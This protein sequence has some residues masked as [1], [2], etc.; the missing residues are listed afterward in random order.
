MI[1]EIDLAPMII[2]EDEHIIGVNKPAGLLTIPGGFSSGT[3]DLKTILEKQ[4]DEIWVVHRL[5]KDTSGI[6]LFARSAEVHRHLN[7]QF[8]QRE[9]SKEYRAIVYGVPRWKNDTVSQ[10]LLVDGDRSH[11]TIAS[12]LGKPARTDFEV[13]HRFPC[14]SYLAAKPHTG[15]T[16]QIRAHLAYLGFPIL[17]DAL[18]AK[19]ELL[20][21]DTWIINRMA[22]H[23]Y[24][25]TFSHPVTGKVMILT[26]PI[27]P[28][29]RTA[30]D[31]LP[32]IK[33]HVEID[34]NEIYNTITYQVN[35][36][37]KKQKRG[38]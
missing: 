11:R 13:L 7:L 31:Q 37:K 35:S 29:F 5:D 9:I 1:P 27:P 12:T 3:P 20:P 2:F 21:E 4:R 32:S 26:A 23:A 22:L 15:L 25:I 28:D 18:Y 36:Q 30:L 10:N 6:V 33:S 16:H 38:S 19:K 34:Y 14:F 8:D 17:Q 24:Q